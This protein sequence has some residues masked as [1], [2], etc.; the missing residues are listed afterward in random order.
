MNDVDR[1]NS[2][3]IYVFDYWSLGGVGLPYITK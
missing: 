1:H 2:T 3:L